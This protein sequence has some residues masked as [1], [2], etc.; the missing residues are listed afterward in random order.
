MSILLMAVTS[1]YG[2]WTGLD[3]LFKETDTTPDMIA[4]NGAICSVRISAIAHALISKLFVYILQ[5]IGTGCGVI[6]FLLQ[7]I[8]VWLYHKSK[9][10]SIK[11]TKHSKTFKWLRL[12]GYDFMIMIALIGNV[13]SFRGFWNI[14]DA[15]FWPSKFIFSWISISTQLQCFSKK[16]TIATQS[17]FEYIGKIN[18]SF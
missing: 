14:L 3:F 9:L 4:T 15:Y 17:N 2:L 5:I 12:I 7:F 6:V 13:A 18:N 10:D 8:F 1:F 16:N 11:P